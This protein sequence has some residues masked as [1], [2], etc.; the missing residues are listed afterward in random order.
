MVNVDLSGKPEE[1]T[2]KTKMIYLNIPTALIFIFDCWEYPKA[3]RYANAM[4]ESITGALTKKEIRKEILTLFKLRTVQK[5][6]KAKH[7]AY[8]LFAEVFGPDIW[9]L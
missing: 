3:Q 5:L 7:P 9:G 8:D 4:K 1:T 6:K 2:Q